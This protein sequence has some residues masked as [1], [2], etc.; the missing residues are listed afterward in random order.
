MLVVEDDGISASVLRMKLENWGYESPVAFTSQDAIRQFQLTEPDLVIMDIALKGKLNGIETAEIIDS[1]RKTPIIYYSS[2]NDKELSEK[3]K[4]LQN[5]DYITKTS[6]D[7]KLKLS[8][9]KSLEKNFLEL[10][11]TKLSTNNEI[12]SQMVKPEI[13]DIVFTQGDEN[14]NG[15]IS[16]DEKNKIIKKVENFQSKGYLKLKPED[17]N[18]KPVADGNDEGKSSRDSFISEAVTATNTEKSPSEDISVEYDQAYQIIEQEL[19]N[20]N[21]HF[22]EVFD[23]SSSQEKEITKLKQSL[24]GYINLM[25]EKDNKINEMEQTQKRLEEEVTDYKNQHQTVL[26]EI[27]SLKNQINTFVSNLND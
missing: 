6:G 18:L 8:I 20:L 4:M 1:E 5:R 15:N 11:E 16:T 17:D 3:I 23:K 12:L 10:E 2:K 9:Q 19:Q 24:D 7:D 22:S 26:N 13:Q 27:Y 25:N 14:M 21:T